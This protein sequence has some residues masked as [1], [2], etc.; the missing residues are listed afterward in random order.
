[1]QNQEFEE[2]KKAPNSRAVH[3]ARL[4]D[5]EELV[6]ESA[7]SAHSNPDQLLGRPGFA[8]EVVVSTVLVVLATPTFFPGLVVNE[9]GETV[10]DDAFPGLFF[11]A[12]ALWVWC[13]IGSIRSCRRLRLVEARLV[14]RRAMV[15]I[16]VV[17]LATFT[18]W[19]AI[20]RGWMSPWPAF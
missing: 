8:F 5:P 17:A 1:L 14:K 20:S 2:E 3:P 16:L 6:H 18:I 13:V 19:Y 11:C 4:D 12:S 10:V 15:S 9:F 7:D